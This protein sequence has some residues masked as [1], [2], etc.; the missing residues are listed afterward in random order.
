MK[1]IKRMEVKAVSRGQK[2]QELR[3]EKMMRRRT[4]WAAIEL[5]TPILANPEVKTPLRTWICLQ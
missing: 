1:K 2:R 3:I 4:P 5:R